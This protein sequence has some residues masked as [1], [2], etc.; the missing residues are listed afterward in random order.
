[1]P[2]RSGGGFY[3]LLER[4]SIHD[5]HSRRRH[6]FLILHCRPL[7]FRHDSAAATAASRDVC[8]RHCHG[9][10]VMINKSA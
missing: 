7:T 5:F 6:I 9:K 2:D 8:K 10:A 4:G 3:D 1:M